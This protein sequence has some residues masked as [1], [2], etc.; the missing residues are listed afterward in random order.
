MPLRLKSLEL[1]GYKT[2]A[3]RTLFEFSEGITAIV[4]PNGSGKSN[5]A[6]A[7]RWVLGEQSYGLLRAKR[8]EDMIF[9]GSESRTRAGMASATVLFDNQDNW[10]PVDFSEVAMGRRAY[11]DG[12]ND[13]LLNGQHVRLREINELLAQSGLGERTYTIL[14]QGLVDASLA[15]KADERRR[16][17]EEAAG[18]GLYRTRR[19]ETLRRLETTKRNLERVLDIMAELEPRL[20][21][22]DRQARRAREYSR[23]QNDLRLILLDWYGYHWHRAQTELAESREILRQQEERQSKTRD[24]YQVAQSEYSEFRQRI[25]G[26]RTQLSDWYRDSS[27]LHDR[28][29]STSREL[30]VLEERQRALTQSRQ[31]TNTERDRIVEDARAAGE[32]LEEA[33][34]EFAQLAQEAKDADAQL[35]SARQALEALQRDHLSISAKLEEVRADSLGL[36]SRRA[37]TQARLDDLKGR[38]EAQGKRLEVI[39][40]S[41]QDAEGELQQASQL[42]RSCESD[43]KKADKKL[44]KSDGELA[45]AQQK[46]QGLQEAI[47]GKAESISKGETDLSRLAAQ[48]EVLDQAE[49]TLVGYAEG[50]RYLLETTRSRS[51]KESLGVFGA[52]LKVP[53]ELESAIAAALGDQLDAVILKDMELDDALGLLDS[54]EAGRAVLLSLARLS[55]TALL[56]TPQDS[57]CLGVAANLVS[58]REELRPAVNTLLGRTLIVRDRKAAQRLVMGQPDTTRVVTLRGEVFQ[59]DGLVVAGRSTRGMILSRPRERKEAKDSLAALDKKVT[60]LKEEHR[61]L[62]ADLQAAEDAVLQAE[63]GVRVDRAVL[64]DAQAAER[65]ASLRR[66]SAER[67]VAWHK[68]QLEEIHGEGERIESEEKEYSQA[69]VEIEKHIIQAA[70]EV[71]ALNQQLI[72]ISL[73]EAQEGVSYWKT[74]AA[75]A[76]QSLSDASTRREERETDLSRIASER[77]R[78]NRQMDEII[79][80]LNTLEDEQV[81][82]RESETALQVELSAVREKIA[83]AEEQLTQ[84]EKQETSLQAKEAD[85]QR[86]MSMADRQF[87]QVQVEVIRRQEA[88]ETLR[89]RIQDDFG[90][91]MFEYAQDVVGPMPLPLDGM[92]EQLPV[93]KELPPGLDDQLARQRAQLRRIG[94]VNP[95]AQKEFESESQRFEFLKTQV[96][97]LRKAEAD[98]RQVISELDDLTRQEFAKTFSAVDREFREV[99]VRLFGGGSARLALT[100]PDNLVETGIEIEARLPG[101][102]EQGLALLSGGERSLTAIALV[103]ALL[104]VSPT[105]VCVMDEVDAMLDEANVGRFRELLYELSKDTQFIIITHNRNTVQVADV[106]YGVTMGRDSVSQIISLRLDEVT[107][108]Y[109]GN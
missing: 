93:V 36:N 77:E 47:R 12:R 35:E 30:A 96:D 3:L 6:D 21:S 48:L 97:D 107:D 79:T 105:P 37:E 1:Q 34:R 11:R 32:R 63:A 51:A 89:G 9:A 73:D 76:E 29:E 104:K 58:A 67:Q 39:T 44:K 72:G 78:L 23:L 99:F 38:R 87:N 20:R 31:S 18:V 84:I 61:S 46:V 52:S 106:I 75:V 109:I 98:L 19:E 103:F 28:R 43:L 83:P 88:L 17:F 60:A 27:E 86:V 41:I 7:L 57:D 8:T 53:A 94:P 100:D 66:A 16:L 68:Q 64:A 50:A 59:G 82:L 85:S 15:L 55:K 26:L 101:R 62:V 102:R 4:G 69:L 13:Y 24:A 22:L 91:V 70:E 33:E 108:E 49:Q 2:F 65:E 42:H 71:Q 80:Q 54:G 92:V 45:K 95:E 10:L 90:L 81:A 25:S 56:E 74:R 40:E 5:I 14:G